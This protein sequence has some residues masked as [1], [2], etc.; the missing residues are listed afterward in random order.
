MVGILY[1]LDERV[2][3]AKVY[4]NGGSLQWKRMTDQS[5]CLVCCGLNNLK[6]ILYPADFSKS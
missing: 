5:I 6:L 4:R 2:K 1:Y 3:M